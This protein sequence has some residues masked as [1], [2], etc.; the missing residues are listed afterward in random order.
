VA[1]GGSLSDGYLLQSSVF[2]AESARMLATGSFPD[3]TFS[4]KALVLE[5]WCRQ[6]SSES[7]YA[8]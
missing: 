8:A 7:P 6:M 5:Q 4:F 1:Y 3:V 2:S